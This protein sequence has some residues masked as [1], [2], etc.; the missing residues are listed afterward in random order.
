MKLL[1]KINAF[2]HVNRSD[3]QNYKHETLSAV[4]KKKKKKTDRISPFY[5]TDHMTSVVSCAFTLSSPSS[6][7]QQTV[8]K[9]K[10]TTYSYVYAI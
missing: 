10:K 5:T 1:S 9:K 3:G 8:L 7:E 4:K 6:Q 2:H